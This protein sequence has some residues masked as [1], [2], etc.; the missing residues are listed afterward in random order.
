MLQA[1]T[2]GGVLRTYQAVIAKSPNVAHYHC[3]KAAYFLQE[4]GHKAISLKL[5]FSFLIVAV[6]FWCKE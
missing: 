4:D 6:F 3:N 5:I 1:G 2:V